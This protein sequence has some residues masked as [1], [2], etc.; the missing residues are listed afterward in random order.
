MAAI[1]FKC[2]LQLCPWQAFIESE[3]YATEARFFLQNYFWGMCLS[4]I[5]TSV[6][7]EVTGKYLSS[8]MSKP[9]KMY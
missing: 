9:Y 5:L 7:E 4:K 6:R 8:S 2:S 3:N 1:C